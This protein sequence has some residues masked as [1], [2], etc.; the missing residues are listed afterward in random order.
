[1]Q[2]RVAARFQ[3]G[4]GAIGCTIPIHR[5]AD[6]TKRVLIIQQVFS[7]VFWHNFAL[8]IHKPLEMYSSFT[9]MCTSFIKC[10]DGSGTESNNNWKPINILITRT[11]MNKL[12]PYL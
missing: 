2:V 5:L 11:S 8:K 4:L 10:S 9:L 3:S 6:P 12:I 1:M 7:S